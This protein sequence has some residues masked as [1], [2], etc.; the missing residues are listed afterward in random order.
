MRSKALH[1]MSLPRRQ[2]LWALGGLCLGGTAK[3]AAQ[4]LPLSSS[5]QNELTPALAGR[6][7]LVVLVSL[8][9]CPWCKVVRENY[10]A[11]MREQEGLHA[12][13]VDMKSTRATRTPS[14]QAT[15]HGTLVSEWGVKFAPTVLF[16][17]AGGKEVAER[18]VG[19]SPDF[20]GAYLE[21]RL[22]QAQRVMGA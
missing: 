17:G 6:Q 21:Q 7:P 19:G 9:G 3:A 8:H 11:P 13:Q 2:A 5:L 16:L 20:Y 22:K 10:L 4:E 15:T 12:V 14:G 18:L 1:S